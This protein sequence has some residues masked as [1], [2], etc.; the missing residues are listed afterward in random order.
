MTRPALLGLLLC[1]ASLSPLFADPPAK[2]VSAL[3]GVQRAMAAAR[4]H[5]R[6]GRSAEA[7]TILEAELLNADGS[8]PYLNLLRDAYAARLRDLQAQ[9]A[10][11]ATIESVRRRLMALDGKGAAPALGPTPPDTPVVPA[12]QVRM[13]APPIPDAPGDPAPPAPPPG[14]NDDPF[15]QKL[16]DQTTQ[17]DNLPRA[18][19][20]FAARRYAQAATLFAQAA[21]ANEP[22]TAGQRDQWAYCRLHGVAMRLNQGGSPPTADLAREV[23]DAMAAGSD[24]VASFGKQLLAEIRKRNPGAVAAPVEAGWQVVETPSFR[25][26]HR[27]QPGPATEVSQT[28]EA[29]RKAMY[30]RWAG[31]PAGPWSPPCDVYLHATGADYAKA[32]GKPAEQPG[33]S[34]VG[35]QAGKVVSRRIDLHLDGSS[36]L[37]ATIPSEVTQVVLADLFADQPLPRWALVGMAALSE[38]SEGV[39]RYQRAVPAL[40]REKKLVAVGPFL[41]QAGFP[42]AAGVTPFYAESVSLVSYLVELKGPKAFATFLREAPRRGYGRALVTH[43]GFKDPADLQ[44]KWVNHVLGG[45]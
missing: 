12:A 14:G 6:A 16:R 32:T 30:E 38:P 4:E 36:V 20:A 25:V 41:D 44:E 31:A 23:E 37:D 2:D 10:D 8:T 5:L 27:G 17:S 34:T 15:Q 19:E 39:A 13:P 42:D 3:I 43:Y 35:V 29:A 40:L 9:K 7:V 18:S 45:E 21:R 26:L 24:H 1:L 22:F 28:A 33:H 11:A